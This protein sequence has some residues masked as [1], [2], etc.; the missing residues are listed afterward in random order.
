MRRGGEGAHLRLPSWWRR[1]CSDVDQ[2]LHR[3][4]RQDPTS[5]PRI[6]QIRTLHGRAVDG[7]TPHELAQTRLNLVSL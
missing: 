5:L 3:E 4:H 7:L 2:P 1:L 6:V